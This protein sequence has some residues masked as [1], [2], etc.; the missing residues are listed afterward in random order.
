MRDG[1]FSMHK[2]LVIPLLLSG[3]LLTSCATVVHGVKSDV[4]IIAYGSNTGTPATYEIYTPKGKL[5]Q[6]GTCP[7]HV[8][9]KAGGFYFKKKRYHIKV[10]QKGFDPKYFILEPSVDPIYFANLLI[11]GVGFYFVDPVTGAMYKFDETAQ[12]T[13]NPSKLSLPN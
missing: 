13:L 3:V 1:F 7:G 12:I 6:K 10:E 8:Q 2:R 4:E 5:V 9:L 11:L